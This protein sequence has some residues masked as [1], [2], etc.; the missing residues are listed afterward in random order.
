MLRP[1]IELDTSSGHDKMSAS[2]KRFPPSEKFWLIKE[3]PPIFP[4]DASNK[5]KLDVG[6]IAASFH[7]LGIKERE[8]GEG[9]ERGAYMRSSKIYRSHRPNAFIKMEEKG[10]WLFP[11][12]SLSL[13]LRYSATTTSQ[14]APYNSIFWFPWRFFRRPS[15]GIWDMASFSCLATANRNPT[16]I[17]VKERK[18]Y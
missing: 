11:F 18:K 1:R 5:M 9:V 10:R 2:L 3:A 12:L 16:I 17:L 13:L 14:F 7:F 15:T 6:S 4:L 8:E